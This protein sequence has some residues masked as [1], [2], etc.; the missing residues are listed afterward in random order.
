M[1]TV[2]I[3]LCVWSTMDFRRL[4]YFITTAEERNIGRAAQ[5]L[6]ISQPPLT[7]QIRMLEEEIG[8][9]LFVRSA[10]GV[11]LTQAG[12]MFLEDARNILSF[13]AQSRDKAQKAAKGQLGRLDVATFGTGIYTTIPRI[14]R[15]FTE[16]HPDVR[17]V[18]HTMTK[19]EQIDALLQ[20]RIHIGFNRFLARH[21]ELENRF[22]IKEQ[23]YVAVQ[24][25]HPLYGQ[26]SVSIME[27]SRYPLI[28]FP[29]TGRPNFVDRIIELCAKRGFAPEISQIV[30]DPVI[31]LVLISSGVDNSQALA[32]APASIISL[33]PPGV[34]YLPIRDEPNAYI[35]LSC[36]YH[37]N[38]SSP[39]L[40]EFLKAIQTF[41]LR[42]S[43]ATG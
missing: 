7:R 26:E 27:L 34:N 22:I 16:Q 20:K 43:A 33:K 42:E 36:T 4:Q 10:R 1:W 19:S 18:L 21:E 37:R 11:E 8:A 32:L 23:L 41:R 38:D 9:E 3:P 29:A 35:D 30:E 14:L 17:V 13:V 12:E 25:Q 28:L 5:R 6:H 2:V 39:V 40:R 31:G 24:D 15:I